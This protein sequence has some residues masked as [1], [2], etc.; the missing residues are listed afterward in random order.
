MNQ[1]YDTTLEDLLVKYLL[2]EASPEERQRVDQWLAGDPANQRHLD[3]LRLIWEKSRRL[4][5]PDTQREE[6]IAWQKFREKLHAPIPSRHRI[7]PH[8][9]RWVGAAILLFALVR[10]GIYI[11]RYYANNTTWQTFASQNAVRTD[12]LPDGSIITLNKNSSLARTETFNDKERAVELKGEA[13]FRVASNKQLP[14]RVM[15]N[16]ILITVLGTSF[17]VKTDSD[18]TTILVESGRISVHNQFG[19]IQL[20]SGET[21]TLSRRDHNL[22]KQTAA[23]QLYKYY[24]PRVFECKDVPLQQFVDALNKAY[25]DSIVIGNPS[26]RNLPITTTFHNEDL[27]RILEVISATF[28][29]HFQQTGP[30]YILK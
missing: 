7:P 3:Q 5:L 8:P 14:F 29:I 27:H 12:T 17:N 28:N 9:L 13:F 23:A 30:K 20:D 25:G 19:N 21:I 6:E 10:A 22:Q 11:S 16:D 4:T 2:Q 26:L 24:Q 18:K 15:T 1:H